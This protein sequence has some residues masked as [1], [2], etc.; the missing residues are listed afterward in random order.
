[1]IEALIPLLIYI[2]HTKDG[3]IVGCH[4]AAYGSPAVVCS[5]TAGAKEAHQVLEGIC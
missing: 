5:L 3:A 1:M 2:V 4:C